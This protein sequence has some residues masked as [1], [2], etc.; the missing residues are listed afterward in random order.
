MPM[1][2]APKER[3]GPPGAYGPARAFILAFALG[4]VLCPGASSAGALEI[5]ILKSS[6]I[7]AYNQ[8]IAGFKSA[9]PSGAIYSEYD[10]RG[11]LENGKKLARKIRAS[12]ASLVLA[13]GLKAALAAKLEVVDIPIVFSMVLDPLKHGLNGSNITGTLIEVPLDRQFATVRSLLPSVKRIG[14]LYDPAKTGTLIEEARRHAKTHGFDLAANGVT[15]ERDVPAALRT[16]LADVG[17]LWL[18][19]DSTV[20]TDESLRFLLGSALEHNVPVI[21]FSPEFVRS[22]ALLSLSVDYTDVGRQAGHLAKR[23]LDGH[24]ALPLRPVPVDRIKM[25]L[26]LKTARFLGIPVPKDIENRADELY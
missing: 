9:A 21:A 4:F 26:N 14:A 12:D 1:T 16:L 24:V 7:T 15:S 2:Q 3:S 10:L 11:D 23:I 13:V 5:A 22:G 8:A 18:I 25:A 19:P 17:A 20:L 6:D